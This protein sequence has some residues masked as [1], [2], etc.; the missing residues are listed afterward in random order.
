M[1]TNKKTN[2][3]KKS[4]KEKFKNREMNCMDI[5]KKEHGHVFVGEI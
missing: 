5:L 1:R 4:R 2:K 3:K